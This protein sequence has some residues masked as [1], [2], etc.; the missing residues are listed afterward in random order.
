[1]GGK[2]AQLLASVVALAPDDGSRG[3]SLVGILLRLQAS[4]PG[5]RA[6]LSQRAQLSRGLY[7]REKY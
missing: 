6:L 3:K 7:G 1:M 2:V 4:E 5:F